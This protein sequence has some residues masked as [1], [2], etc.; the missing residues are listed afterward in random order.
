MRMILISALVL[1][2]VLAVAVPAFAVS[3]ADG[4]GRDF[5]THHATHARDMGGFDG[6]MNPG[7]MHRGFSGWP[8][9]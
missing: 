8:M 2:L 6:E 4:A 9:P 3:G 5:G 7:V 1:V